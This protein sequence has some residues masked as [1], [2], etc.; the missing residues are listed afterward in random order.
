MAKI[1]REL[2]CEVCGKSVRLSRK[3]FLQMVKSDQLP[4]C[5]QCR[6]F[7]RPGTARVSELPSEQEF[8]KLGLARKV[9]RGANRQGA[10][11]SMSLARCG[12]RTY[13]DGVAANE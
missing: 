4:I 13:G 11:A 10:L 5:E 9:G 8:P 1:R 2:P 6:R 12:E 7:V 3:R